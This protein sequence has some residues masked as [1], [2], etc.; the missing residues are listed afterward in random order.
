MGG[1]VRDMLLGKKPVDYD[2]ATDAE[3]AQVE[4]LFQKTI[5]V[6]RPF[7]VMVVIEDG[8]HF[9]VATFR[10][11]LGY[12]DGRHPVGV[13]FSSA[14]ADAVRRDF[15]INGL[16]YDPLADT[17]HDW[18]GGQADLEK[19][20]IRAIGKP[21]ERFAEDRLRIL[22]AARFAAQLRFSIEPETLRA[23]RR[24][25][26]TICDISVERIRDELLKLF[27]PEHAAVGLQRLRDCGLLKPV[28]PEVAATIDCQ[29]PPEFHPE[30]DVFTHT[31]NM[32]VHMDSDTE[33]MLSWAVLLHD[34]AKPSTQSHDPETGRIR[35]IGHDSV[36]AQMA[37]RIMRRL[38]FPKR[39]IDTVVE[40]I[41]H[42]MQLWSAL[43]MRKG[44]LRKMFQRSAFP[45]GL[46]LHRLDCLGSGRSLETFEFLKREYSEWKNCPELIKPLLTGRDLIGMGMSPGRAMGDLLRE[47]RKRQLDG[48][49]TS[50]QQA[51]EWARGQL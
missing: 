49:F 17:I 20:V 33:P 5:D 43:A 25:A 28:L 12:D 29:Q 9:Q 22:R 44:T 14:K 32:L 47:I 30:G 38:R 48:I 19:K 1:C 8:R 21:E 23:V 31:Q 4:S 27:C 2:L 18:V 46:E 11:D 13:A 34:I 15:T 40:S 6:G 3:P 42:H 10:E 41:R 16:F 24:Q 37:R 35:F 50:T 39:D 45:L 51:C 7:G 26:P 36:G